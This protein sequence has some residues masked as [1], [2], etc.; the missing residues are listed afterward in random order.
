MISIL[1]LIQIWSTRCAEW[2]HD[3]LV[4][5]TGIPEHFF[6]GWRHERFNTHVES[7]P[8]RSRGE[9]LPKIWGNASLI[10]FITNQYHGIIE[11]ILETSIFFDYPHLHNQNQAYDTFPR[12]PSV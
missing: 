8:L 2:M 5:E 6:A 1:A 10:E 11:K 3:S 9:I 4:R 12:P 7:S